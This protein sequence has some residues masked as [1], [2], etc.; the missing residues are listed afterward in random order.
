VGNVLIHPSATVAP[1]ARLGPDVV[2]GEDCVVEDGARLN[3]CTL[4]QGARVKAHAMV[5][6]SIVGWASSV[7]RWARVEGGSVLGEDVAE[8][9]MTLM[10]VVR[11]L[12]GERGVQAAFFDELD[13]SACG[14]SFVKDGQARGE[15]V[16]SGH[17]VP[18]RVML[19]EPR[20]QTRAPTL[21]SGLNCTDRVHQAAANTEVRPHIFTDNN[22][23][24]A[25][26]KPV[27]VPYY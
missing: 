22:A 17:V 7:G 5:V 16:D 3:N 25:P 19:L 21:R 20:A 15:R 10:D 24:G 13:W 12:A 23:C 26:I 8:S 9:R 14:Y 18:Q 4:L 27:L 1:S 6:G 2:V 11:E